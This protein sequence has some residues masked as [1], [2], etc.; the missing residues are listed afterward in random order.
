MP[1]LQKYAMLKYFPFPTEEGSG[2]FRGTG[3]L[4]LHT[5]GHGVL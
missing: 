2:N 4:G 3:I 1:K 5:G